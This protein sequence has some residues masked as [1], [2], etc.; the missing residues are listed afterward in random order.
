MDSINNSA[1]IFM[2]KLL[3]LFWKLAFSFCPDTNYCSGKKDGNY[4]NPNDCGTYYACSGGVS[5]LMKCPASLWYDAPTDKCEYQRNANCSGE[6]QYT[7]YAGTREV[8][9]LSYQLIAL[10][11]RQSLIWGLNYK[12]SALSLVFAWSQLGINWPIFWG[13][14]TLFLYPLH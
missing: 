14:E 6:K 11:F 1:I 2:R 5:Y 12:R 3:K 10:F 13:V 4:Q 9:F 8:I 7:Y